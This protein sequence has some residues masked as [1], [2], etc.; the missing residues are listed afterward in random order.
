M[1]HQAQRMVTCTCNISPCNQQL[2]VIHCNPRRGFGFNKPRTP[3]PVPPRPARR[4]SLAVAVAVIHYRG[5]HT[6]TPH[7]GASPVSRVPCPCPR[8]RPPLLARMI[9]I[10]PGGLQ[11]GFSTLRYGRRGFRKK[12]IGPADSPPPPR[13]PPGPGFLSVARGRAA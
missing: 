6:H 13:W 9:P 10:G 1:R 11:S 3:C 5:A 7:P 12:K 8:C 2:G 4:S